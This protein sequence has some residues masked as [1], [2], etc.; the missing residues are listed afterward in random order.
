M[1]P[2]EIRAEPGMLDLLAERQVRGLCLTILLLAFLSGALRT[3]IPL[4]TAGAGYPVSGVSWAQGLFSAAWPVFGLVAGTMIDRGSK[5]GI[6]RRGVVLFV[7]AQLAVLALLLGEL[8]PP[9]HVFAYAVLSG[10]IVVSAEAFMLSIPPLVLSGGR[11]SAFYGVALFL[12]YGFS[13]FAGPIVASLVVAHGFA[14]FLL[15]VVATLLAIA[16]AAPR[17]VPDLPGAKSGERIDRAY[18]LAGFRFLAGHPYLRPLTALT[19]FLSVTFGAFLTLFVFFVTDPAHLGLDESAY[20][21]M[22]SAYAIGAMFGAAGLR[23]LVGATGI[24]TAIVVDGLGTAALLIV[25]V[26]SKNPVVVFAA[27][28]L[29]GSGLSLWFVAV[30]TFRQRLTPASILGRANSA[31]RVVGYAGMPVGS[32]VAGVVGAFASVETAALAVA[33]LMLVALAAALPALWFI[34]D[35][36]RGTAAA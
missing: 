25:P 7:A 12:D 32:L 9:A 21:L 20:G 8:L 35:Y 34:D 18:V 24:R 1:T 27:T 22:I 28:F 33:A 31:F 16:L 4:I 23:R 36:D 19:F 2:T 14:P 11:L 26:L 3:A 15:L 13:F 6:L 17:G 30:T 29:A 10:I 5:I